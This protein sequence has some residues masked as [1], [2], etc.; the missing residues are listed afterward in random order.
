MDMDKI[1]FISVC[2]ITY[3]HENFIAQAI[4][5]ILEQETSY[6]FELIIADDC[7]PDKTEEIVKGII[8]AHSKGNLIKYYRHREN[9]GMMANFAFALNKCS[10]KY[11][12]ICEGDDYWSDS[13]KLQIQADFLENNKDFSLVG[14]NAKFNRDGLEKDKLVRNIN[15]NQIDFTTSDMIQRNPFVACMVMFRNIGFKNIMTVFDNFV[16]GDKAV[17][18][19][20]SFHGKCRFYAKPLGFYRKHENSVTSN[21]RTKYVPYKNEL[22]NR[23]KHAEFWNAYSAHKY[24]TES[25]FVKAYRSKVLTNIALRHWDLKTA[26]HYSQFVDMSHIKKPYSKLGIGSLKLLAKFVN[27]FQWVQGY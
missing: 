26:V 20:L 15:S 5:N 4:K 7:S 27:Y 2:M 19:L 1:P 11:I 12:A 16:V 23:I 25:N 14:H 18:T 10:G 6:S 22:I 8:G 24:N 21:N 9:K 17:F 3:G 13:K